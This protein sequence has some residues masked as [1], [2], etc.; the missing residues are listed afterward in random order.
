MGGI[1]D[2]IFGSKD[3]MKK[4]DTLDPEQ[5]RFHQSILGQAQGLMGPQGGYSQALGLLQNYL[6]PQSDMFKNFEQ[7]YLDEFNQEILPGIAE[8]YA[9]AGA[10]SSSGFGQAIGSAGANLQHK[11]A[12]LKSGLQHQYGF[13]A[14]QSLI[15]QY[16]NLAQ[17][18]LNTQTFSYRMQ[19]GSNGIMGPLA[20]AIGG[21]AGSLFN[22]GRNN[23]PLT[24]GYDAMFRQDPSL[25]GFG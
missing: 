24:A 13:N 10:L 2:F 1:T 23:S 18:G 4:F 7:P 3:K 17:T 21:A 25:L 8:Q 20:A 6:N 22:R 9:G 15:N 19:P 11:L 16:N 5:K 12:A 14:A